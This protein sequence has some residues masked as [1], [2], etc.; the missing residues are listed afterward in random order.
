MMYRHTLIFAAACLGMLL[1][2][3]VFLSLG[4]VS[5]YIQEQFT[6]D[7]PGIAS[8]ASILPAGMLV[9][10]VVFGPVVDRYGYKMLLILCTG[11]LVIA[12]ESVAFAGSVRMLQVS[13]FIIGFG[14]GVLNG[15]TNALAS[16]ITHKKKGARLSLLGVFFGI[17]A[18]G[19]PVVIGSLSSYFP[20]DKIISGIGFFL[21]IPLI[22]FLFIRFPE[23]KLKQG[24]PLRQAFSLLKE[25]VLLLLGMVLF[26]ESALEGIVG[27][28]TTSYLNEAG[29]QDRHAL[30]ALSCQVAAI[31]LTRLALSRLLKNI[32]PRLVIYAC[33]AF[34]FTGALILMNTNS[35]FTAVMGMICL[36]IGFAAGFPV[37]LGYVGELYTSVSGTAFS[38]VIVMALTGNTLLNY[39]TGIISNRYGMHYFP[40]IL[41][42][43][44]IF[45]VVIF[46]LVTHHISKKIMV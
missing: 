19:M 14:G 7:E 38:I 31:A 36:G 13:Y 27:N 12:F 25:P 11:L 41:I 30:Y 33:L 29:L 23:P 34:I 21:L 32:S 45:M 44:V 1:F 26:F 18:L 35:F 2:G 28:W 40:A 20:V 24:F 37:I 39:I 3:I 17:G 4:T 6:A 46:T 15:G 16:D 8:L 43:C 10:S 5:V 42:L 9:G 22:F